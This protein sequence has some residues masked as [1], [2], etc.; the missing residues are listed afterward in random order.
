MLWQARTRCVCG[1]AARA[2]LPIVHL[3]MVFPLHPFPLHLQG[4]TEYQKPKPVGGL[5]EM[6]D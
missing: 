4:M 2:C 5:P 6:D 3:S 1:C